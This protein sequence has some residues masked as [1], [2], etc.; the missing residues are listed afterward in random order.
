M[1]KS[2]HL[3]KPIA[4]SEKVEKIIN[5]LHDYIIN[6]NLAPGT[7]IPPERI[8]AQQL[9]VSRFSLREALR[10][11]QMQGLLEISRGRRPRVAQPTAD[12]AAKV[13]SLTL[14]RSEKPLLDLIVAREGL[15]V[16]IAR[17]A[18]LKAQPSHIEAMRRTID[19]I[20][21][22]KDDAE[23]CAEQDFEFHNILVKASGNVV[24]EIMLSPVAELL[25]KSRV[26][27]IKLRG[28]GRA[29]E[30]HTMILQAVSKKDPEGAYSAMQKHLEM[31]EE[32]LKTLQGSVGADLR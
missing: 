24:F 5:A 17:L 8:L 27:T 12:A 25:R 19:L 30:G 6:G 18:A 31:A 7:E 29:I 11:A 15:E 4:D 32:D 9:G 20:K 1:D 10:V 13:M 16:Q 3:M 2:P 14:Q 23:F 28:I 26:E 22:R 21:Q